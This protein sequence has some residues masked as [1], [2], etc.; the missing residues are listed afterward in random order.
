MV[1]L[2]PGCLP[3]GKYSQYSLDRSLG[4]PQSGS[5]CGGEKKISLSLLGIKPPT[6]KPVAFTILSELPPVRL[7]RAKI[8]VAGSNHALRYREK[9]LS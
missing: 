3:V 8:H 4:G 9:C 2:Q 7:I 5:G 6:V 1:S